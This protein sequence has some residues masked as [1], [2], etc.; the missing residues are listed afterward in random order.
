[1]KIENL[2]NI[3]I[4]LARKVRLEK[5]KGSVKIVGGCD[6]SYVKEENLIIGVFVT[7]EISRL[8]LLEVSYRVREIEFPYIPGFLSF[9]ELPVLIEAYERIVEK[10]DL[11][12]VDG[13][14][15]LHPRK[16]GLASHLGVSLV[17]PTIGV[18]KSRLIGEYEEPGT[19]RGSYSYIYVDGERR[20]VVLRTRTGVKPLFVS[21]GNLITIEECVDYVL[22]VTT[23]YRL[24]EP[25]RVADHISKKLK[26]NI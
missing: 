15:I 2:Q 6:A 20:G 4:E 24:P 17:K 25:L 22:K 3:Q 9:R 16:L 8:E 23:K 19:E 13:Q 14:G 5:L 11:I 18:A 12:L 26:K 10:P 7:M 21:P 1:M